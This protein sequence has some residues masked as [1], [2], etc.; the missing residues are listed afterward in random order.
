M[1][2]ES[3][4][5]WRSEVNNFDPFS[6][7]LKS[8]KYLPILINTLSLKPRGGRARNTGIGIPCRSRKRSGTVHGRLEIQVIS[9]ASTLFVHSCL[10][11]YLLPYEMRPGGC[12]FGQLPLLWILFLA[13]VSISESYAESFERYKFYLQLPN[14]LKPGMRTDT[15]VPKPFSIGSIL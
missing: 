4:L 6:C 12:L 2:E 1:I 11:D 5:P 3:I 7:K 15:C 10:M 9:S 14:A 8:K 13:P